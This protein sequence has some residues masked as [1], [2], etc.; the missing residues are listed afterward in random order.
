MHLV[1]DT[2]ESYKM[3]YLFAALIWLFASTAFAEPPSSFSK[4]KKLA[5]KHYNGHET[6]FYCGCDYGYIGKKLIPDIDSCGYEPR[7]PV[8]RKGKLN[9]RAL[10]IEW[11]HVMPAW[12]FGHQ[13]QC[14]QDGGRKACKKDK[15]F[16]MMEADL[17]NLVPAIGELNGDRSNYKFTMIPDEER[18]YGKCDFE[19]DF[20]G[21]LAEPMPSIRGDVAR[22]YF[23]MRD[24]YDL[25]LS[26]QQTK[27]LEAWAKTD[28]VSDVE[29]S[30]NERIKAV[31]GNGNPWVK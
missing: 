25:K 30:R 24:Q 28:P 7:I 23:Y 22:I 29:R 10:R 19:V 13:R 3:S 11:E 9:R 15:Q 5:A 2:I 6:T 21:K 14:W 8:T 1:T 4:A 17:H 18:K 27:L 31:Q 20:K 16:S 12:V 26:G